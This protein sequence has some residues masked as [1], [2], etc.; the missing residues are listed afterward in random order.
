MANLEY[1]IETEV[2]PLL[3]RIATAQE[4]IAKSLEVRV[5]GQ[6]ITNLPEGSYETGYETVF[7]PNLEPKRK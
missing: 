6:V 2:V 1:L 5:N 7:D 4:S 3:K